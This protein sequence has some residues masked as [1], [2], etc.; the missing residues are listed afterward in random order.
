MAKRPMTADDLLRLVFVGD[1][2]ISPDGK[3]LLIA[4]RHINDK[5]KYI[6]N[7][8]TVDV[9]SRET[10]QWTQ[11]DAGA[12]HGR[13]SPDG[14]TISFISGRDKPSAQIYLLPAD[15]GEARKLTDFPEGAIGGFRWSPD[16][17]K[18][19]VS[20]RETHPDR[21]TKAKKEREDKGLSDPAWEIDNLWYRMDGDGYFGP[22]RFKLYMVD[23]ATG[24]HELFYDKDVIGFT[25]YDWLP[26]GSGLVVC[27]SASKNPLMEKPNDQMWIVDLKG[28][29]KKIP[30]NFKGDKGGVRVSP[31]GKTLAWIGQQDPA[32]WGVK[33]QQL[34]IM[35][36][37]G[38]VPK[39]L[40]ADDDWCLDVMAISDANMGHTSDGGGGGL[41]QW[42]PDGRS[43]YVSVGMHGEAQV[44][45]VDIRKGG[46]EFVTSGKQC[47]QPSNMS[48]DGKVF[49]GLVGDATK[50]NEAAV[51]DIKSGKITT[52]TDANKEFYD[53][54]EIRPSE[55]M[56]L[57]S[58]DG[59]KVHAWVIKPA[60]FKASK[61]HP[62]ILEVH[63]GPHTQYGW[64]FFHEF[65]MLA[66]QGYVVVFSNPRGSKGY[67]ES[68]C[69]A[70]KGAWGDKDWDDIQTV[71]DWM[72]AQPW[73]DSSRI[74]IMGGSY[75]GYMTNWAIGHTND[76]RAAITDR[77][78]S[79]WVSMAGNSDFPMNKDE[80]FG[81]YAWGGMDKIESLWNQSPI[82]FFDQVKTPTLIIHSEGDLRCN[83]E[84]SD[85]VFHA[86]QAQGIESRYV[87]YPVSTSHGLSRGGPPD[88]RLH[89]LGEITNWWKRQLAEPK[90]S[91][92]K[93]KSKK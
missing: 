37:E 11:G 77:C 68:F 91:K 58:T 23:A 36:I 6:T 83:V 10:K 70:I 2:Q 55:D 22:Q 75:G 89:R 45:R 27:H 43:I 57:D 33:N 26:D 38:G 74:G 64:A 25:S 59:V 9:E 82:A 18:F 35:P 39:V 49:A 16:G 81:G 90:T 31:D 71:K 4:R 88:L 62:A 8:H 29:T 86:L 46:I 41:V 63:G 53:E 54:V 52:L 20:F 7:L 56:W 79:N 87:R 84:Q 34:H 40:T 30:C 32:G 93:A 28:K 78:V 13:W 19:V 42:S 3:T 76:F 66:A 5:N 48:K 47:F 1:V 85:Q 67:G 50:M 72:K 44:G 61:K 14:K 73:I 60:D 17:T 69:A 92:S 21:T 65:Q 24:Q 51:L 15:G 80:Y 12:G